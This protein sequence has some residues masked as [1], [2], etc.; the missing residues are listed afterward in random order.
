MIPFFPRSTQNFFIREKW[1]FHDRE[2]KK[3]EAKD[4]NQAKKLKSRAS[5]FC[6][7]CERQL[8]KMI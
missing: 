1:A 4:L 8:I 7:Y 6:D 5:N 2:K 3:G